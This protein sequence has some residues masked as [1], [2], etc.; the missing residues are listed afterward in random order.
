M[1]DNYIKIAMAV[2]LTGAVLVTVG[3]I[4]FIILA[5]VEIYKDD[6]L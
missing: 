4:V 3:V 2:C 6:K 1:I 5:L